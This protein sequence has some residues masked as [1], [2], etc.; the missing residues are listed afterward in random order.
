VYDDLELDDY[1]AELGSARDL[2]G[3]RRLKQD[4]TY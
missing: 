1:F 3:G 4:R 2:D